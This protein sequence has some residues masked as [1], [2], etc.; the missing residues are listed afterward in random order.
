MNPEI[1]SGALDKK[2]IPQEN[3]NQKTA[4]FLNDSFAKSQPRN[5]WT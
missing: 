4:K 2:E 1:S 5:E 3:E